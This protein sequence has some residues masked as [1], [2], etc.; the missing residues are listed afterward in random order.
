MNVS[1]GPDDISLYVPD[2]VVNPCLDEPCLPTK[3]QT[4][5]LAVYILCFILLTGVISA[6]LSIFTAACRNR[7]QDLALIQLD[8]LKAEN[9]RKDLPPNIPLPLV[10]KSYGKQKVASTIISSAADED[11]PVEHIYQCVDQDLDYCYAWSVDDEVLK[12]SKVEVRMVLTPTPVPNSGSRGYSRQFSGSASAY[13][14]TYTNTGICSSEDLSLSVPAICVDDVEFDA[15]S[16]T[17]PYRLGL[18]AKSRAQR[19]SIKS[20]YIS[21]AAA[22]AQPG[23]LHLTETE[24]IIQLSEL[25]TRLDVETVVETEENVAT[26]FVE[27]PG[28]D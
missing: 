20:E 18:S 28:N 25:E 21:L 27:L 15:E 8:N 13:Q 3:D 24:D 22:K 1:T 16:A 7:Y 23:I 11:P 6:I 14:R 19:Q 17:G 26:D 9:Y 10:P 4:M 5:P 12:K 2:S